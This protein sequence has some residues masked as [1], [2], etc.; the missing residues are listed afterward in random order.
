MADDTSD[1]AKPAGLAPQG[2]SSEEEDYDPTD[3][4]QPIRRVETIG[5]SIVAMHREFPQ[6]KHE[7]REKRE[8]IGLVLK[9]WTPAGKQRQM[10]TMSDLNDMARPPQ[11]S[12]VAK[13]RNRHLSTAQAEAARAGADK[14]KES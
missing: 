13:V 3:Q 9:P 4:I 7:K 11:S 14:A 2:S 10:H 5:S 8:G 12:E 6:P 1:N